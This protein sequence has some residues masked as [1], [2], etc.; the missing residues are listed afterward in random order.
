MNSSHSSAVGVRFGVESKWCDS[1]FLRFEGSRVSGNRGGAAALFYRRDIEGGTLQGARKVPRRAPRRTARTRTTALGRLLG[2]PW[3]HARRSAAS[4]DARAALRAAWCATSSPTI[5][6]IS[7]VV[8]GI[9]A[10]R[11]RPR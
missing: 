11:A 4:A 1:T 5:S 3:R 9:A 10:S 6:E 7:F 8:A 2:K